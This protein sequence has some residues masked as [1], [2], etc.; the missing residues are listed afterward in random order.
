MSE[1]T[2]KFMDVAEKA[3]NAAGRFLMDNLGKINPTD[4]E[5]K[6]NNSFVTHVDKK[7]EEII[8][9]QI[10][11]HFPD[12]SIVAEEGGKQQMKSDFTWLIDPLD[13]T[14]NFIQGLPH[15]SVSIAIQY[16][17][18]TI[19]GV[20][21]NPNQ[22]EFFS[23]QFDKGAYLN[24]KPISVNS[25]T[26]FGRAILATGFPHQSKRY[27]PQYLPA[28]QEMMLK[29]SGIRRWGSAAMDLCYTACGRFSGFWELGLSPWDIAAGSLIVQ[30]A[31]GIVT[32]F[33]GN[34]DYLKNGFVIAG[35]EAVWNQLKSI[36]TFHFT[37]TY[38]TIT[39]EVY[40]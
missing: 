37:S 39:K 30:E 11:A 8:I 21:Y 26:D 35:S 4:V 2:Q 16:Q 13:G 22:N 12:H 3:A 5:E 34:S 9:D 23:A 31:G 15:F 32:D 1:Q 17:E 33:W 7:S 38:H 19:A 24:Q 36:L 27:L 14:T 18:Q 6:A 10:K 28:F 25:E 40:E 20:V 29:C